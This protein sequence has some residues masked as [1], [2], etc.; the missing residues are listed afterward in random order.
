[1][2]IESEDSFNHRYH[3]GNV[4]VYSWN[5]NQMAKRCE[6]VV[7]LLRG[8]FF[9]KITTM[10][11]LSSLFSYLRLF[12]PNEDEQLQVQLLGYICHGR[13]RIQRPLPLSL[14][15]H[16]TNGFPGNAGMDPF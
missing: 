1:M 6:E 10:S 13:G 11:H 8:R 4:I 5:Y 9:D 7:V 14:E 16:V 12:K 3:F 2:F 15:N